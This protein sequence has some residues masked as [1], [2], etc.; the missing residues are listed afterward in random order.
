MHNQKEKKA[1]CE[2]TKQNSEDFGYTSYDGLW[3]LMKE[4]GMTKK[5]LISKSGISSEEFD[6]M[7]NNEDVCL[8]TLRQICKLLDCDY[9]DIVA[10]K[11]KALF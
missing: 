1:F 10:F 5:E 3:S 7:K 8:A 11:I 2:D 9:K 4:K 6:L